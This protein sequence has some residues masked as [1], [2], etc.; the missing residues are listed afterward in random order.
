ML[1]PA[2][3]AGADELDDRKKQVEQ[4]IDSIQEDMEVLDADI[5]ETDRKLREQQGQL[6]GAEQALA[7]ARSRVAN[8]QAAV[9]DLNDRLIAAQ[10]TRDELAAEIEK[11]SA[12]LKETESTI[13]Q[14]ASEAYKR[15]GMSDG[16]DM[17]LNIESATEIA[18]GITLASKALESQNSVYND[19]AQ[20]QATDEN[21]KVRLAAVEQ[22]IQGLK[23]RPKVPWPRRNPR[24]MR[25]NSARANWTS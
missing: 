24:A 20:Q 16:L 3:L 14:I 22:Q 9:A 7:D 8:A 10:Q 6:P 5:V 1:V 13:S 12:K 15:G 18:D 21:N 17:I 11:N 4:N 23:L 2:T 19:L 25:P